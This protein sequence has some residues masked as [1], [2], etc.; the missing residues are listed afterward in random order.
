MGRGDEA[1]DRGGVAGMTPR[2]A[3]TIAAWLTYVG[4]A[5]MA[6]GVALQIGVAVAAGLSQERTWNIMQSTVSF[7]L[8]AVLCLYVRRDQRR[9][10]K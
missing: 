7:L 5:T 3:H 8:G 10:A 2:R 6:V 4:T 9:M 1:T